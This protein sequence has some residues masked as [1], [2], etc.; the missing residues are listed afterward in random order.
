MVWKQAKR[1]EIHAG[2][3]QMDNILFFF[4]NVFCLEAG[5]KI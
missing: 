1:G 2:H 4:V 5:V 3:P